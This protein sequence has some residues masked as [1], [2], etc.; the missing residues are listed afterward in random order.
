[1]G[2]GATEA[3]PLILYDIKS[4]LNPMPWSPNVWKTRLVLNYKK[5]PYRT[6]WLSYPEIEPTL[7]SLGFGPSAVNR[8][9]REF[10][11]LPAIADPSKDGGPPTKIVDSHSIAEYLDKVYP[12]K[13]IIPDGTA[14]FHT[15]FIKE[16]QTNVLPHFIQ[17]VVPV[18]NLH[19]DEPGQEYFESTRR[20][21]FNNLP[22]KEVNRGEEARKPY[23]DALKKEFD[24][25]DKWYAKNLEGDFF[26][27]KE[28]SYADMLLVAYFAW[29]RVPSDRDPGYASVWDVVKE[30][31]EGRWA[32]LWAKFEEYTAD[33]K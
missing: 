2:G 14:G 4:V 22:L 5:I 27:G 18:V 16:M 26:M 8:H 7:K 6:V 29:I 11:T 24:L 20:P 3:N 28:I 1:M 19:L 15:L 23:Y 21:L 9:G 10:Y 32:R 31:N 13:R 33:T 30:W 25:L 12:Q 17:L